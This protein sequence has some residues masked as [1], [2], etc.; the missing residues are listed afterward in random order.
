MN[1]RRLRNAAL[2][3]ALSIV[4]LPIGLIAWPVICVW[5]FWNETDEE[6]KTA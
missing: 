4:T 5:F 2:G 3:L 1:F 6:D